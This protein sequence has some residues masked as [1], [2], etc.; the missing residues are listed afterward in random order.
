MS[1]LLTFSVSIN[2]DCE[3]WYSRFASVL[4]SPLGVHVTISPLIVE[5]HEAED[6][7][8]CCT[9]SYLGLVPLACILYYF[10]SVGVLARYYKFALTII[11]PL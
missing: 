3:Y 7:S 4:S 6:R 9:A 5:V 2:F 11:L 1:V 10:Y 8:S